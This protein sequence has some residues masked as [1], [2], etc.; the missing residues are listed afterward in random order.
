MVFKMHTNAS[1]D[2][3]EQAAAASDLGLPTGF[4]IHFD[5]NGGGRTVAAVKPL[6]AEME[7]DYPIVG[8]IEDP[9]PRADFDGWRE[10]RH[11][12]N[13]TIV[14]GGV[15]I[16]GGYPETAHGVADAYMMG[17]SV[18]DIMTRG[19]LASKANAQIILQLTGG[20]LM[21]AM[22]LHL[23]AVLPSASGHSINLDD[24]YEEDITTERIPVSEGL[25]P[26]PEAPGLGLE[27]DE[28]MLKKVAANKQM[29][30]NRPRMIGILKMPGGTT[31]HT[32]RNPNPRI[33]TGREEGTIRGI[34]L[35]RWEDD[36]SEEFEAAYQ[37]M[38]A[39]WEAKGVA[40]TD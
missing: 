38:K 14:H 15:P 9:L 4:K 30:E 23:A 19:I 2:P 13:L 7:R 22:T 29:I 25:S 21:K 40:V 10:L 37:K 3:L 26:V 1:Y 35:E 33:I 16:G 11:H 36:G 24:Q 31:H 39:E 12:T 18:A 8:F 5:F 17:H 27:V 34:D 6:I 20:T 28:E 32:P